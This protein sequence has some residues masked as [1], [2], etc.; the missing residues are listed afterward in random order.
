MWTSACKWFDLFPGN[1]CEPLGLVYRR[2]HVRVSAMCY[3]LPTKLQCKLLAADSYIQKWFITYR[4]DW[5]RFEAYFRETVN[6]W[7]NRAQLCINIPSSSSPYHLFLAPLSATAQLLKYGNS[8]DDV[9]KRSKRFN[10]YNEAWER[11]RNEGQCMGWVQT[12]F[13]L[14]IGFIG[15][16]ST[17]LVTT[18]HNSLLNTLVSSVTIFIGLLITASNGGRFLSS[19]YPNCHQYLSYSNC[20]LT[21]PS[22]LSKEYQTHKSKSKL[23]YDWIAAYPCYIASARTEE[24][25]ETPAVLTLFRAYVAYWWLLYSCVFKKLLPINGRYFIVS[26]E[27]ADQQR[28]YMSQYHPLWR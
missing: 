21:H 26:F 18:F 5:S 19:G 6:T 17:Q 22:I 24:K 4:T 28:V 25:I 23:L 14:V 12:G 8:T 7:L 2:V 16:L 1:A 20:W 3:R 13:G 11:K 27:L 9:T 10:Q 15:Q